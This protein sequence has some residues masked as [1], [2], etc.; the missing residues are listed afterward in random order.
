M[1]IFKFLFPLFISSALLFL[2]YYLYTNP[3]EIR[4]EL[5][6]LQKNEH[7]PVFVKSFVLNLFRDLDTLG[8]SIKR[9]KISK[10]KLPILEIFMSNGALQK[11]EKKRLE[12][13]NKKRPILI[14]D[15]NDWVK[16]TVIADNGKKRE[17]VKVYLRLKGDWGDHLAEPKKL[18]FRIKVRGDGYI[19]GMKKLSIQHPKTRNYQYEA[20]ILDMM[21][22]N[23]ILA[24]RYFLVDVRIN[25]YKIGIMALE[26]HFAKELI[27]YEERRDAPILAIDE[28]VIWKQRDINYNV[29]D[30]NMTKYGINPDWTVN[31]FNDYPIKQ[32]KRPPFAKGTIATNNSVRAISL[33]RD[34]LDEKVPASEV[35]D[36]KTYA[37]WWVLENIWGAYHGI[38]YQN[39]RFYFNPIISKFEPVAFDNI[40]DPFYIDPSRDNS[41]YFFN[42]AHDK[43]FWKE[44][45]KALRDIEDELTREEFKKSFDSLQN[46][47]I[48]L[49]SLEDMKYP[50]KISVD[51]LRYNLNLFVKYLYENYENLLNRDF[52]KKYLDDGIGGVF[53]YEK[54][55]IPLA[56]HIRAFV[57]MDKDF[58]LVEIKNQ[59]STPIKIKSIYYLSKKNGKIYVDREP[60]DI[61][62]YKKG[63]KRHIV[64]KR[65]PKNPSYPN[66]YKVVI[67]YEYK[68]KSFSKEAV[69]QF[70]NHYFGFKDFIRYAENQ[71][72]IELDFQNKR[73]V[74]K[75]GEYDINESLFLKDDWEVVFD[76][77]VVINLKN[78]ALFKIKG[79]LISN[80][81]KNKPVVIKIETDTSFKDMGSWGGIFVLRGEKE[82]LLKD[83]E[84]I[85]EKGKNLKNR[86]DYYGI[87]GCVSFYESKVKVRNALF[88]NMQCED[89][90]NI[91]RSSFDIENM[92][93]K[94]SR[95]DAFDS[96]FSKGEIR[97]SKFENI[98]NDG[99]DVSGTFVKVKNVFFENVRDKA[100]SVGEK[101][102]LYAD[103]V[104]VNGSTSGIVSKD[105]SKA[106]VKNAVFK[107]IKGSA[108]LTFIKKAEYGSASIEC[109]KCEF[110]NV[111]Y[112]ASNQIGSVIVIDGKKI[113]GM[114]FTRKQLEEAG[115]VV[116]K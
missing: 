18:S 47:W 19:F 29:C 62:P 48:D 83:T 74:F 75:E 54:L 109:E 102:T 105:L 57:F 68:G 77:G 58:I 45:L 5:L 67:E 23:S 103:G 20:L 63:T 101:S 4:K 115:L 71:K 88:L 93:I 39:K 113:E 89:S 81:K 98:G 33:L 35:F 34:Y 24:P 92:T 51:R 8:F 15:D 3:K 27:E 107:N 13:L 112:K 90:L 95:A 111:K 86:Q 97:D 41:K 52:R 26:E 104:F 38:Y 28:S 36:Y 78:G 116:T 69:L 94:G 59:T 106:F 12:T 87:T 37:R 31:I 42:F 55:G 1:K 22:K 49:M 56:S 108:L 61:L 46:E 100:V 80:G 2:G 9:E 91:V 6:S 44:V 43:K 114:K 30:S 60:F 99:I 70:R 64:S 10:E 53:K 76:S 82:S 72:G 110:E 21:R 32:F 66:K 11:I 25:G 7:I 85:G 50:E 14:T 96:D 73:A 40:P 16:A 65:F 79:S 17:K 84:F